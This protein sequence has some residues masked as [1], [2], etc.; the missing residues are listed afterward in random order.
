VRH[1]TQLIIPLCLCLLLPTGALAQQAEVSQQAQRAQQARCD[2]GTPHPDSPP[3]FA[4][5]SFLVGEY[6]I[7]SHAWTGDAWS[8][9]RPGPHAR[10]NGYYGLGGMAIY[11]EWFDPDP[12][13]DPAAPRGV[14]VRMFDPAESAWKMMWIATAAMQVLDLRAEI[15][16]GKL[17]MWQ[18]YPDRPGSMSDFT[19]EDEDHWYRVSYTKGD[20]GSWVPQ[21]KLRATRIPCQGTPQKS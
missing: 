12:A 16:D 1:P 8:P 5:F 7:T 2:Y 10:W 13:I 18:V 4:Q 15:R 19:V 17:T 11:D 3:E 6:D 9:A 21:F 14:N 20:D